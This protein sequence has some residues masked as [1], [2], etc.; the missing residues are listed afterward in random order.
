MDRGAWGRK[1]SDA[2]Q[3]LNSSSH[4]CAGL[5]LFVPSRWPVCCSV[6]SLVSREPRPHPSLCRLC[7]MSWAKTL[8]LQVK[9]NPCSREVYPMKSLVPLPAFI[10]FSPK[11]LQDLT[12]RH[13]LCLL[14][15]SIMGSRIIKD[16]SF[17]HTFIYV[18]LLPDSPFCFNT[19]IS[20]LITF[21]LKLCWLHNRMVGNVP[22]V[23][24]QCLFL[25]NTR[26]LWWVSVIV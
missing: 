26:T 4:L 12:Q 25:L 16:R 18:F 21:C 10:C 5:S 20:Y 23:F 8:S 7:V 24:R 1:E 11:D 15:L 14:D 19:V 13:E 6:T 22:I 9:R 2:I 17:Q 3:R